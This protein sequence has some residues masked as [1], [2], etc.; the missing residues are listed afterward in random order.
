[1]SKAQRSQ[2]V[3][4]TAVHEKPLTDRERITWL[5]SFL[6]RDVESL[7]PG[8]V[9]DLRADFGRYLY[10]AFESDDSAYLVDLQRDLLAGLAQRTD[11]G[12]WD[13]FGSDRRAPAYVYGG[14][15]D[16]TSVRIPKG[17]WDDVAYAAA[18]D[19]L[20]EWFSELRRCELEECRAWFLPRHGRQ[21]YHDARCSARVRKSRYAANHK[22][23]YAAEYDRR[24]KNEV[25]KGAI[26]ARRKR[27][28]GSR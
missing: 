3:P 6:R 5:L 4:A 25:G 27:K 11:P 8:E 10:A 13:P 22:R 12:L 9:L 7:R 28:A 2:R 16:G 26:P 18:A 20:M 24:V 15:A 17:N 21:K 1:M 14:L 19:L 23:D